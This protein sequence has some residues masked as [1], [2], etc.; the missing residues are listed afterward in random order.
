MTSRVIEMVLPSRSMTLKVAGPRLLA[1]EMPLPVRMRTFT[2]RCI[3]GLTMQRASL[4][5]WSDAPVS[6]YR[7]GLGASLEDSCAS[8]TCTV[9][10]VAVRDVRADISR[11]WA[12][13][14]SWKALSVAGLA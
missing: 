3:D 9:C 7:K 11:P 12:R 4:I 14:A 5:M 10:A 6:T 2:G 13:T 1:W 8:T